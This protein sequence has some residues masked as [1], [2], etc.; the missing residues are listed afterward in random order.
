MT[1]FEYYKLFYDNFFLYML[2][3]LLCSFPFYKIWNKYTYTWFD[4]LRITIFT[5]IFTTTVVFFLYLTKQI[6]AGIFIQFITSIVVFWLAFIIFAKRQPSYSSKTMNNY[7]ELA[8]IL[9]ILFLALFISLTSLT[10]F[11]L[12]IPL[13]ANTR[14]ETYAGSGLGVFGR[15]IPFFKTY[16]LFYSFYMWDSCKK[17]NVIKFF[18]IFVFFIFIVTGILSGSRSSFFQLIFVFWGYHHFYKR[19]TQQ[20]AR[21][22]RF[23]ILAV[24]VSIMSFSIKSEF[25]NFIGAANKFILRAI[26]SGDNYYMALPNNIIA[27][28]DIGI[29]YKHLFYGLLGPLRI[30]NGDSVP[31][32]VGYQL[33]WLTNPGIY[34][35]ATGPLSSPPLLGYI[36]F[37]WGGVFFSLIIGIFCSFAIFKLPY[38]L[39][40]G[41]ITSSISF[42]LYSSIIAFIGDVCLG[43]GYLFDTILNIIFVVVILFGVFLI[44]ILYPKQFYSRDNAER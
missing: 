33:T 1:H 3:L 23:L 2:L 30:I 32:P 26:S 11:L 12:G 25:F 18:L 7:G 14:L 17:I 44:G 20:L 5:N 15:L 13:L 43:M 16:C 9:F 4:P 41:V 27:N 34:G 40:R 35:L 36:Y 38:M 28:V 8:F 29:W 31:P 10:Y 6:E 42:Y 22:Y 21:Y 24:L 19:D 37:G 39:P